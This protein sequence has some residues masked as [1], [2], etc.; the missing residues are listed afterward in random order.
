ME[1]ELARAQPII[2]QSYADQRLDL[3][4]ERTVLTQYYV[5]GKNFN[6]SETSIN[7]IEQERPAELY[8]LITYRVGEVDT[9]AVNFVPNE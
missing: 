7:L 9:I 5:G 4:W 8:A 1:E 3:D 6:I 2:E